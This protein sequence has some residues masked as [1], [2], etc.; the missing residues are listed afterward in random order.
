M[1]SNL[2]NNLQR[3]IS[4]RISS[5]DDGRIGLRATMNDCY[6][7][8]VLDV[9]VNEETLTIEEISAEFRKCP[10]TDCPNA[11]K[12]LERLTGITI[13]R[14]LNKQIAEALGGEEGCGNLRNLLLG[15]L[16]LAINVKAASGFTDEQ[17]MM[18]NVRKQMRGTCA[19][20]PRL[21]D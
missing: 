15:L 19:G 12:R 18:D 1:N 16:P 14:G 13:G 8:I 10:T 9:V 6:H 20:Y 2:M 7:D 3:D 11:V 4:Y 21:D 17:A 5:R